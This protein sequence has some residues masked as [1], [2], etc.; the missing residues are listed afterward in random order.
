ME[1]DI[2]SKKLGENICFF[3]VRFVVSQIGNKWAKISDSCM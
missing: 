2:L 3:V 1:T